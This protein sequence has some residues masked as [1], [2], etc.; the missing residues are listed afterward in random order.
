M[1]DT[2]TTAINTP[3]PVADPSTAPVPQSPVPVPQVPE[4]SSK[5]MFL[6]ILAAFIVVVVLVGAGIYTYMMMKQTNPAFQ[7]VSENV[8]QSLDSA[9]NDISSVVDTNVDADF[10][11]VDKEL[12]QL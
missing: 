9:A 10:S 1:P 5:S 6:V 4:G 12:N 8:Q 3:S 11:E 2:V 7:Q